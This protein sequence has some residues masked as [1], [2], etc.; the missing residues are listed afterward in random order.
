M[1]DAGVDKPDALMPTSQ[2]I[3][4]VDD[5]ERDSQYGT[6]PL[7]HHGTCR[8][9]AAL[10][11]QE[12]CFRTTCPYDIE[13]QITLARAETILADRWP[14]YMSFWQEVFTFA[15]YDLYS[16]KIFSRPHRLAAIA[17]PGRVAVHT[18]VTQ[19]AHFTLDTSLERLSSEARRQYLERDNASFLTTFVLVIIRDGSGFPAGHIYLHPS[20]IQRLISPSQ[21]QRFEF[22]SLSAK[23]ADCVG[24]I[25]PAFIPPKYKPSHA[26]EV[27]MILRQFVA[28]PCATSASDSDGK[29]SSSSKIDDVD[30][31]DLCP[32]HHAEIRGL[33]CSS[34]SQSRFVLTRFEQ[35]MFDHVGYRDDEGR[36]L[37]R[38][39]EGDTT[40][41]P[42]LNVMLICR[43]LTEPCVATRVNIGQ[44]YLKKWKQARP[45]FE[46]VV[47]A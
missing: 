11:M 2:N 43:S 23:A 5:A 36:N 27:A 30:H 39:F 8:L 38:R 31:V 14:H 41:V 7:G 10:L 37:L 45:R 6:Y 9:T 19:I 32:F 16:E 47:L 33:A 28:C 35:K 29:D 21:D 18:Q 26:D 40:N 12:G 20:W 17:R 4:F 22:I 42:A 1:P 13:R 44:I 15:S 3:I 24:D 46:T 25:Y 34:T